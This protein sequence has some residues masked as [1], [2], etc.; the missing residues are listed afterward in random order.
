MD[1]QHGE[2]ATSL[3]SGPLIQSHALIEHK[4]C[5][6]P[7]DTAQCHASNLLVLIN[8]DILCAWF[9]GS[10]EGK[11]DISIYLARL[12]ANSSTWTK[13]EKA[14][15]DTSRSEQNPVLFET[16]NGEIWLMFTS[17]HA[18]DQD[19]AVVKHQISRDGGVSW[20]QPTVLFREPGTFIRQPMVVLDDGS[21]A[22]PT[23]KCRAEPGTRWVGND[24]ISTVRVSRDQGR[25]WAETEVPDSYGA[26][27]MGIRQLKDKTYL[28]LYRS[29]WADN[30]Y[31]SR[32]SNGIDWTTP[33][34]TELPN[35]NAG[36]CFDV[37]P[38][39]RVLVV[40]N[41]SS[42]ADAQGRR[43]GLYDDIADADDNR[44]NQ[45]SRHA[46]REAFWGAPRAPLCLAWSDDNGSSWKT[47]VLEERDGFCMT[48]NREQK[49]NRELSY[50]SMA[51]AADGSMHIAFTFWRQKIKHVPLGD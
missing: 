48:N 8:G 2:L 38:S 22:I 41:H 3:E 16:P 15:F 11:P 49:L 24:D 1:N 46:G 29:R 25:T 47:R 33:R 45:D 7:A 40:Y 23:F 6:V 14:T 20:T 19:S 18:G 21:W 31:L 37:L 39:G 26:V 32:S 5:F 51:R 50:P 4:E 17:Q 9:G 27:H 35:P 34:P 13:A 43:E 36:I 10:Q 42:K 30:V 12:P 28:G 44:K